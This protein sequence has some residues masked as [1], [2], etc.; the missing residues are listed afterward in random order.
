MYSHLDIR[1]QGRQL[2]LNGA[3]EPVGGAHEGPQGPAFGYVGC[4]LSLCGG[5]G[6][7]N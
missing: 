3:L 7:K 5:Q 4:V 2:L 6:G 1:I